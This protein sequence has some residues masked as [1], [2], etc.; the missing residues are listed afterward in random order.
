VIGT[1]HTLHQHRTGALP[2]VVS[3]KCPAAS[4]TL[5]KSSINR[6][7]VAHASHSHA[8][9]STSS[10]S[11]TSTTH[12]TTTA[13][14]RQLGLSAA[15]F[16]A[17]AAVAR[18]KPSYAVAEGNAAAAAADAL[19]QVPH[20]QL[21]PNAAGFE[22]SKVIKGCWQL[23]GGHKGDKQTDRTGGE[24]AVKVGGARQPLST[25]YTVSRA[26]QANCNCF[27]KAMIK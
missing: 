26:G 6:K 25:V 1:M 18:V 12:S 9:D 27:A 8:Q 17:G 14:K 24:A 7:P 15:V 19:P 5:Y 10:S 11:S 2:F 3:T 20:V 4:K 13:T 22:V 16:T 23:S 21:A